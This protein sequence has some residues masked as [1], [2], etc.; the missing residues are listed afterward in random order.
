[1]KEKSSILSQIGNLDTFSR[2]AEDHCVPA[3]YSETPRQNRP[4]YLKLPR[5]KNCAQAS[6][7][8]AYAQFFDFQISLDFLVQSFIKIHQKNIWFVAVLTLF[9]CILV[10]Q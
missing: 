1:M 9:I 3:V 10:C 5:K 2:N 7:Y 6:E 8:K 4:T